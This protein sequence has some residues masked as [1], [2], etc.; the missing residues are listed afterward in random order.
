MALVWL[1]IGR[2]SRVCAQYSNCNCYENLSSMVVLSR[3]NGGSCLLTVIFWLLYT[4][5]TPE[6]I[7]E[8]LKGCRAC[9]E[10]TKPPEV[11][12]YL[13]FV[14][15]CRESPHSLL[16]IS[17]GRGEVFVLIFCQALVLHSI[18]LLLCSIVSPPFARHVT[19][20]VLSLRGP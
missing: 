16:F 3:D 15:G 12:D 9:L 6:G 7:P 20:S 4:S 18:H 10:R 14:S 1:I 2:V 5:N 17:K 11:A 19:P 8:T 13:F